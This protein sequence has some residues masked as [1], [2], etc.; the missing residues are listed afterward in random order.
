MSSNTI[1]PLRFDRGILDVA[2]RN[3]NQKENALPERQA[4]IPHDA[5]PK[6]SLQTLYHR[7][8]LDETLQRVLKPNISSRFLAPIEI[9]RTRR[10]LRKHLRKRLR[11]RKHKNNDIL[12]SLCQLLDTELE[13]QAEL[14]SNL[15]TLQQG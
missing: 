12:E 8:S 1:S 14:A 5:G 9:A 11:K 7:P 3:A 13:L 6:S 2:V 4:L 15:S 10:S